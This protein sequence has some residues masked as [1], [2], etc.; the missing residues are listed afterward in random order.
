MTDFKLYTLIGIGQIVFICLG[1]GWFWPLL[2]GYIYLQ[3]EREV[4]NGR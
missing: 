1:I 3:T 4:R 2:V